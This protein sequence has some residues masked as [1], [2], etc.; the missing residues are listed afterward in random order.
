[1]SNH[2]ALDVA[3]GMSPILDHTWYMH[4]NKIPD[5]EHDCINDILNKISYGEQ[6]WTMFAESRY[7][8]G[9]IYYDGFILCCWPAYKLNLAQFDYEMT[10]E[11]L[12]A[13]YL[14]Y[15]VTGDV[16]T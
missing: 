1:M 15:L 5:E 11:L 2:N 8:D 3:I 7:S 16:L 4:V 10:P 12:K 13:K 9:I 6:P 14:Q